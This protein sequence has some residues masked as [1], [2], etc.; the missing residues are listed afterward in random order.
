MPAAMSAAILS[1]VLEAGPI[2]Q[3]ILVRRI[4]ESKGSLHHE[5][6]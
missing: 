2:V 3:T 1:S 6:G 5:R 4:A